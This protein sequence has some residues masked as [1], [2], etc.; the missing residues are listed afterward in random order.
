M[1]TLLLLKIKNKNKNL[2]SLSLE[3][4]TQIKSTGGLEGI[5]ILS[6]WNK[7][8]SFHFMV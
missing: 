6:I 4:K 5:R 7:M 2:P 8:E 3:E 1:N